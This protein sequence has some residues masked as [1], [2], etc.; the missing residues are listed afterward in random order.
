MKKIINLILINLFF[1]YFFILM[2]TSVRGVKFL[3]TCFDECNFKYL[4]NRNIHPNKKIG[5]ATFD[6]VMGY[7]PTQILI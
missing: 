6:N 7:L 3:L 4:K 5:I 2:E 1:Y